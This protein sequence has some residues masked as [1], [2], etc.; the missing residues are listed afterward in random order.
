MIGVFV[1][2]ILP[3][4]RLSLIGYFQVK[5]MAQDHD[6]VYYIRAKERQPQRLGRKSC[7]GASSTFHSKKESSSG[8][9]VI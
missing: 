9:G 4:S 3:E 2:E 6:S 5:S 1:K 8:I 7:V